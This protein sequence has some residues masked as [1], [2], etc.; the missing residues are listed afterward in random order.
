MY[1]S[2]KDPFIKIINY[3]VEMLDDP[4]QFCLLIYTFKRFL[5][6]VVKEQVE[7][8]LDADPFRVEDLPPDSNTTTEINSKSILTGSPDEGD[9][10][11]GT[12]P[13]SD[14]KGSG[15]SAEKGQSP[16]RHF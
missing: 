10:G 2:V 13:K 1:L 5:K 12:A 16:V 9:A 4:D 3:G 8:F 7:K 6:D 11:N 15:G 14:E